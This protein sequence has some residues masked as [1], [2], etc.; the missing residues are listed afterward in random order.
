MSKFSTLEEGQLLLY[1]G[2]QFEEFDNQHPYMEF[3]GYDSNGWTDLWV[4]YKGSKM[5]VDRMDV[6]PAGVGE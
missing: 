3:L 1:K 4:S 2:R 5:R 6:E